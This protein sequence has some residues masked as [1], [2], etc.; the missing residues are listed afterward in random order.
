[1]NNAVVGI[2]AAIMAMAE[3]QI[4]ANCKCSINEITEKTDVTEEE[5]LELLKKGIIRGKAIFGVPFIINDT[6][7]SIRKKLKD[8]KGDKDGNSKTAS[9]N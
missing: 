3:D 5:I 1:M 9:R 6:P 2:F 4:I 8:C 7:W